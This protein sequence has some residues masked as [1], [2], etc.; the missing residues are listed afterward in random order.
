MNLADEIHSLLKFLS[1]NENTETN[2]LRP[3]FSKLL[4]M[5]FLILYQFLV[6]SVRLFIYSLPLVK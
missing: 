1:A 4:P 5:L 3:D 6:L 2:K